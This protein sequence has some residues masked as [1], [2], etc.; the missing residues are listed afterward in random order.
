MSEET[1]NQQNG[2][3][4]APMTQAVLA[5]TRA[6]LDVQGKPEF[7]AIMQGIVNVSQIVKTIVVNS[8]EAYERASA[9]LLELRRL[10]D[11]IKA[12]Q[13][14]TLAFSKL[15]TA[16]VKGAY[17]PLTS[18]LSNAL[19]T[20][21]QAMT[22]WAKA[23]HDQQ[24][25]AAKEAIEQAANGPVMAHDISGGVMPAVE[26][27]A[28]DLSQAAGPGAAVKMAE[29]TVYGTETEK[30]E[31]EDFEALVKAVLSQDRKLAHCT[32]KMLKPDMTE[33]RRSL[34]E[35]KKNIP[36]V[37]ADKSFGLRTRRS[38]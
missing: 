35:D 33:I 18:L 32:L 24:Q 8:Q 31:I 19:D 1:V 29:G 3:A 9:L 23:L 21:Q 15:Y 26:T 36:G 11:Y 10:E 20:I 34:K 37:T 28:V 7:M 38:R 14:D 27:A 25:A 4:P 17:K 16:A 2:N 13:E 22:P 5:Q 30:I 12:K 6:T